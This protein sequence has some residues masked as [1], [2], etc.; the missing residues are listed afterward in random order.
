MPAP[1][2][3][4]DLLRFAVPTD[5]AIAPDGSQMAFTVLTQE[6][7]EDRRKSALWLRDLRHGEG[8]ARPFTRGLWRDREPQWS[9]DG[10]WLAFLSDREQ[11]TQLWIVASAGGEPYRVT[12]MRHGVSHPRWSPDGTAIL[13]LTEV[14]AGEEPIG[15]PESAQPAQDREARRLRHV[16]RLQ[17]RWDGGDILEGRT[18]IWSVEVAESLREGLLLHWPTPSPLTTGDFDHA[19]PAWS[20]DGSQ[21]AFV[22][23]RA[24]E[25]DANRSDDVWVLTVATGALHQLTT[26]PSENHTPSWSPDGRMVAWL[27]MPV[28]PDTSHSN[29]H[30]WLATGVDDAWQARDLLVGQD[31]NVGHG[32]NC[33]VAPLAACPPV[34]A[35]DGQALFVTVCTQG[36]SNLHRIALADGSVTPLTQ[37]AWQLSQFAEIA[38]DH[39]FFAIASTPERPADIAQFSC[40]HGPATAPLRWL[41]ETNPWLRERAIHVPQSFTYSAPDGW[42]I[43]GW[44][45]RPATGEANGQHAA[46]PTILQIHGGPHGSYGPCFNALMQIFAG[47]GYAVVY[48]NPR[49][50]IGYGE[51]FAR[52]CDRDWGG[53]DYLDVMAGLEAALAQGGLDSDRL[54]VTG[55][56]Y[57]GY[58]TNWII[59]H[60]TRFKAAVTINSVSNLLSSF[61]TSD[62][63]AVF[64]IPEQG[65]TL[66]ERRDFYLERSPVLYAPDITTPTR[67]IGAERDWRCPIEQSEQMYTALKVLGRAATDFVRVPAVSHSINSGSPQ[68]RVAQRRAILEWIARFIPNE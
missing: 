68:Q 54:A 51:T 23:D 19:D 59:S 38:A 5:F 6:A 2:V 65:G 67:V 12:S 62:V 16:T 45:I 48:V 34:W 27:S 26:I 50:S 28:L 47:A 39:T 66:W 36:T 3:P 52:A 43:Q 9:P 25:R 17:Y 40:E 44:L 21:I 8:S 61:G 57:G 7:T 13:F 46:V 58:L 49:G 53:A 31:V 42:Q 29:T 11:G 1:F 10:R 30:L 55:T 14:R 18:Q 4:E 41:T 22:S 33:D 63:D 64:G 35:A 20:P 15:V 56:S 24:A 37:G 32:I 60:T